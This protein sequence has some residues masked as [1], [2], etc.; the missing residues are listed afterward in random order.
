M[1][2]NAEILSERCSM[3]LPVETL[4][5]QPS[6]KT[7][8]QYQGLRPEATTEEHPRAGLRLEHMPGPLRK[9]A[10]ALANT[11]AVLVA[12]DIAFARDLERPYWAMFT[13]FI[14]ANPI[15]GAVRSK[16]V[17]RLLGTLMGGSIALFLV[18][19]L[20]NAPVLLCLATSLWVGACVYL[21]LLDR[22]PRSYVFLLAGYTA[23]IVGLAVVNVPETI[24][25][26]TVS[27]V[28]EISLG[29]ICAAIAHSL[30]FPQNV[31]A[32]LN[33]K[34]S[35]TLTSAREWLSQALLR[36]EVPSD[37]RAQQKLATVVTELHVLY[38]HVDFETSDVP[39]AA[40][41]MRVLQDR[42]ALLLPRVSGVQKAAAA[43]AASG[44]IPDSLASALE[45]ASRWLRSGET[46]EAAGR[47]QC[48]TAAPV[49]LA[50]ATADCSRGNALDWKGLL[51]ESAFTNLRA[52]VA[53]F[54]DSN[55]LAG[56]LA[57]DRAELPARLVR[58]AAAAGQ[59]PLHRD[60]GLA[61]L[62]AFA[63]AG[64]TLL[65]CLLWIMGSWPEG[66]VAAQ[67]AAIGCSLAATLD[68]P[69]KFIRAAIVGILLALPLAALYEFAI[70]PRIDGF[71]SLALVLSPVILLFSLMQSSARLGGAGLIFAV[72]FSGGLALQ[73]TYRA[74][75][76]SFVN[77]NSAEIVGLLVAIAMSLVVRTID[78]AWNAL[79][80][81]RS[82]RKAVSRLATER[83]IDLRAWTL[84]MFDRLGLVTSRI[85]DGGNINLA[86]ENIDALR[87]L[88]VGLNI[89]TLRGASEQLGSA[90]RKTLETVLKAV[91]SAY[92]FGLGNLRKGIGIEEVID[93][94]ITS[95]NAQAPSSARLEGLAA[96]TGLRLDLVAARSQTAI[97]ETL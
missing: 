54:A 76:A 8:P 90:S 5:V 66:A 38:T 44:Q 63:A 60:R 19:P 79:R 45:A 12:L 85:G 89:G 20:V 14:V 93:R 94:G 9:L 96:L 35:A 62:S 28:E 24:F 3:K 13:V 69:A 39:R 48:Q 49:E 57:N 97:P 72:A 83:R 87:D 55:V 46:A 95:L 67:F 31:T 51:E 34:I 11:A 4:E 91:S 43:L 40:G 50:A 65:A 18:P 58:E 73:D 68:N 74:D 22:T 92:R 32:A 21:S 29:V 82:G 26:T 81:S 86:Q 78:P 52:L 47:F 61:L 27:R 15:A 7:L 36:P 2:M 6:S 42:L 10:F 71:I 16:A 75:F 70:L 37:L 64:A 1:P 25:D 23:T 30:V 56:A 84:E 53:A 77:S 59:Q 88:R 80:I 41:V 17:Y 33:R